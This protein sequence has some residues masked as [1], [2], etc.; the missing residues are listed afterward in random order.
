MNERAM[1][2]R[3][4]RFQRVGGPARHIELCYESLGD[5][6]H[7]T[8]L[9][10]MGL[11][12]SLDWWRD[13]FCADLAA[14]GFHVVRFDNRDVG[15]ST[16]LRGPGIT[17]AVPAAPRTPRLHPR[18]HGRRRRGPDRAVSDPRG[19]HVV[20]RLARLDGGAGGGDPAP[21]PHAARWSRSWDAPAT[22]AP[23]GAVADD[24]RSSC[25]RAA[26]R[27]G[28]GHGASFRRIGSV[29]RTAEDDED[30]RAT[31]ARSM[32]ARVG[33]GTGGGP[34]AR[35]LRRRARPHRRPAPPGAAR[36]RP[37]RRERPRDPP[38]GRACHR[39]RDPG[40][41]LRRGAR[42]GTRPAPLGLAEAHRRHRRDGGPR[43]GGV[44]PRPRYGPSTTEEGADD[45]GP[46]PV[47]P[48]PARSAPAGPAPVR[49]APR[50]GTGPGGRRGPAAALV[51]RAP[52]TGAAGAR[53]DRAAPGRRVDRLGGRGR[54]TRWPARRARRVG[55]RRRSRLPGLPEP[56]G[57]AVARGRPAAARHGGGGGRRAGGVGAGV[58][59]DRE[60]PGRVGRR[61]GRGG[62]RGAR[63]QATAVPR[64][65]VGGAARGRRGVAA[66]RR[67]T[68]PRRGARRRS[69]RPRRGAGC[70]GVPQRDHR[71][72]GVAAADPLR[73]GAR[74]RGRGGPGARRGHRRRHRDARRRRAGRRAGTGA[75]AGPRTQPGRAAGRVRGP[76]RTVGRRR[77]D[78]RDRPAR[79]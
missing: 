74:A 79:R 47:R 2:E 18:R 21:G 3:A 60:R 12:L 78:R 59:R 54:D 16:H 49:P 66:A 56:P 64:R 10:I 9:L 67:A 13:D 69:V 34:P 71:P 75:R 50:G 77:H 45:E 53:P 30:V 39:G 4:E 62:C 44:G 51:A 63:R 25:A 6:D 41:E 72:A 73:A 70:D 20:G 40:A 15:R 14:R 1:N 23:A 52:R 28:G 43:D 42:D 35:R 65:G 7:P 76:G 17:A 68:G 11:G 37:A 26:R 46:A 8:V 33:D 5:P 55:G 38:V 31:C 58:P 24:P 29:G 48:A 36:A 57:R 61:R 32:R 19:A 22:G 27:P